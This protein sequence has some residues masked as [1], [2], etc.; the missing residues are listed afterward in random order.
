MIV[1]YIIKPHHIMYKVCFSFDRPI[2][3]STPAKY[4]HYENPTPCKC[5]VKRRKKL[6]GRDGHHAEVEEGLC[7]M[8]V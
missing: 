1:E 6:I 2:N 5:K 8:Q 3:T 7:K 4:V